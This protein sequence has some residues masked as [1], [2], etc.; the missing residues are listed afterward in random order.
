MEQP[1]PTPSRAVYGGLFFTAFSVLLLE[2]ALTRVFAILMWHHFAYMVVS[3]ALLGFG[4][5]GSLLTALRIG[6]SR[7][8]TPKM[9]SAFAGIYGATLVFAFLAV[10]RIRVDSLE[11]WNHPGNF[12]GLFL[13][14]ILL[15][16]PFLFAG[17]AI[18]TTLARYPKQVGSL[19]FVDL[20]GSAAGGALAPLLLGAVG[21]SATVVLAAS[22]AILGSLVYGLGAGRRAVIAS[23]AAL[24]IVAVA[25]AGF[26]G[27]LGPVPPI[28]WTIP[29][30]P[31]KGARGYLSRENI[32]KTLYSA[33]AQVDI[34]RI[35]TSEMEIGGQFG[36]VD[37]QQV[38]LRFVTQD[39][40]APTAIHIGASDL[41]RFPSLDDSQAGS[42]YQCFAAR[43]ADPKNVL[44][45][46]AGGGI[47]VMVA[48]Y[49]GAQRVDAVE[50]NRAMV[51]MATEIYAEDLGRLFDDPRV[52]LHHAEGRAFLRRSKDRYDIIQLS[53]VDTYTALS[54]GA[55][56]L[57]ESYLYTVEA[58]K[59]LYRRLA[60]DGIANY[61]RFILTYTDANGPKRP[62]ETIRLAHIAATALREL[63]IEEPWRHIAVFAADRAASTMI[64]RSPFTEQELSRLEDFA[65]RQGFMGFVFDPRRPVGGP[66]NKGLPSWYHYD[67]HINTTLNR[68]GLSPAAIKTD[69]RVARFAA[70]FRSALRAAAG[71]DMETAEARIVDYLEASEIPASDREA[72]FQS[73]MDSVREFSAMREAYNANFDRAQHDFTFLLKSDEK[74]R[75]EFVDGYLFDLSPSRDDRPF[76]FDYFKLSRIGDYLKA[77]RKAWD[78]EYHPEFPVG[79]LVI[80]ASLLQIVLL[81]AVLILLPLRRLRRTGEAAPRR[82]RTFFYFAALGLGFMFVE[83]GLMQRFILFLG[84]PTLAL[85]VVLSG[86]LA[87]SGLGALYSS[88]LPVPTSRSMFILLSVILGLIIIELILTYT[89]LDKLLGLPL[90]ARIAFTLLLLLPIGF[91]L[92]IPFPLGLRYL[93]RNG[94]A[95]IP[96]GWAV[97]GFLSVFATMTV[98]FAAMQG[99]FSFVI[100]LAGLIYAAGIFLGPWNG[101]RAAA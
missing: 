6:R 79:H 18:G 54:S 15:S 92:G 49:H 11:I 25:A 69:P 41:D 74:D 26:C 23:G 89:V 36:E 64:K 48:L 82:A 55:Y 46:G 32:D 51:R 62:R 57:S 42:A 86:M 72:S 100:V 84:H 27:G 81:A 13:T 29:F 9:L 35:E 12:F 3:L 7:I 2:V 80:F 4:A 44:V 38:P 59:D 71:G 50:I 88:R 20:L 85:S 45:I 37:R 95:L 17:C 33:T 98:P 63:G 5:S 99:G 75:E 58:V 10:T 91:T 61:S 14:Y 70:D 28:S 19:Y 96:W 94:R 60:D 22:A 47:D 43:G 76:F 67:E 34:T 39:G 52:S 30:A 78:A 97:N 83:I 90:G 8:D 65:L 68:V 31:H 53:G 56:T 73:L 101:K 87:F 24:A 77:P 16:I 93:E 21:P 40:T 1:A 66:F